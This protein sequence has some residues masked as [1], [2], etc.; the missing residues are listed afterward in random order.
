[1]LHI[2][3]NHYIA[4]NDVRAIIDNEG[5]SRSIKN[6]LERADQ[7]GNVLKLTKGKVSK[8][9]IL[10]KSGMIYLS[11]IEA[12]TLAKRYIKDDKEEV[13]GLV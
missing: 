11:Y 13:E 1:M 10:T 2:G 5:N 12:K 7:M 9:I 3:F 6:F 4:K 8:T